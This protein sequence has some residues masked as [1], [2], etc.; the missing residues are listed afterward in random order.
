MGLYTYDCD[1]DNIRRLL[2]QL[3]A[4]AH[5]SSGG[6]GASDGTT[7]GTQR[8]SGKSLFFPATATMSATATQD[9]HL[10]HWGSSGGLKTT[11]KLPSPIVT[12]HR[13]PQSAW[14]SASATAVTPLAG[15]RALMASP[16]Q[17]KASLL[18]EQQSCRA[19]DGSPARYGWFRRRIHGRKCT[20]ILRPSHF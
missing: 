15:Q 8:G 9:P 13:S 4:T 18:V 5:T 19:V 16:R 2:K 3:A 10:G 20:S 7:P 11:A 17:G 12:D 14:P 6:G 1:I